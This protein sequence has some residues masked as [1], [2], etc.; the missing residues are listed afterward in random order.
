MVKLFVYMYTD[1]S[2]VYSFV[3]PLAVAKHFSDAAEV[4]RDLRARRR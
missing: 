2:I 3:A 1:C 4:G